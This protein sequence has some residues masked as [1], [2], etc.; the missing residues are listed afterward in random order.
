MNTVNHQNFINRDFNELTITEKEQLLGMRPGTF[1][2][3]VAIGIILSLAWIY[4]MSL[5]LLAIGIGSALAESTTPVEPVVT[6]FSITFLGVFMIAAVV[7]IFDSLV[8]E[9]FRKSKTRERIRYVSARRAQKEALQR[10]AEW[11]RRE[12][13]K[14]MK[15]YSQSLEN[16]FSNSTT[17]GHLIPGIV[18]STT[19]ANL[20]P[21]L[22]KAKT[23]LLQAEELEQQIYKG[24]R[25]I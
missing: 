15:E 25:Y 21:L 17:V 6:I 5:V 20:S 2:M 11:L 1:K 3:R 18:Q 9:F 19:D 10:Q 16:S 23:C 13:E 12:A 24:Y 8:G 4:L 14:L 22:V 7:G